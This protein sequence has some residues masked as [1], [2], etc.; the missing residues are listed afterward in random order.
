[1]TRRQTRPP[2]PCRRHFAESSRR[3][4]DFSIHRSYGTH[5]DA[6]SFLGEDDTLGGRSM[7]GSVV[8][9]HGRFEIRAED[10]ECGEMW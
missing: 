3:R 4:S 9:E 2:E 5:V 6:R 1:M 7:W 10:P 8:D